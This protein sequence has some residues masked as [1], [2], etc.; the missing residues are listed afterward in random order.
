M[1]VEAPVSPGG[2]DAT[3]IA[4]YRP[5][6]NR[7]ATAARWGLRVAAL[8]YVA[9]ILLGPLALVFYNTFQ[10]GAGDAWAAVTSP[11]A[12]HALYLTIL[13]ALIAV[14]LNAVFGVAAAL[15]LVRRR[16]PGKP[17]IG[18]LIDLPLA[19]SPVVVGLSIV[20]VWGQDGW[21]GPATDAVGIQVLFALPSMVL[22]T[23]FV[24]LPFVVREVVPVLREVGAD[25]EEAASTLGAGAGQTFWRIT[26]PA[27]RWGIIYG[28]VLTTAR[29]L[30]EYGAVRVV[31]GGIA[32]K[33]ET[34]TL[35]VE[36]RFQAFDY[37]AAYGSS[38]V[39]AVLALVVVLAM[40]L[41]N[42]KG[43][44]DGDHGH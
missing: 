39:L 15:L 11:A 10:S 3:T 27:I 42:R 28:V 36:E 34:M 18:A 13:I 23:T 25:Q 37:V 26:L 4:P 31:S 21:F 41:L 33:T 2:G 14:P 5:P 32:E 30:G 24:S 44:G 19:L 7:G 29:A 20:L 12:L 17:L 8:G 43:G 16:M 22:A 40:N 9:A 35:H 38:M 6:A 1:P